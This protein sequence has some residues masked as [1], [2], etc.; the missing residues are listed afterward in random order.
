MGLS[1]MMSVGKVLIPNVG[2]H[3]ESAHSYADIM[4]DGPIQHFAC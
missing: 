4:H 2:S 3:M 1:C